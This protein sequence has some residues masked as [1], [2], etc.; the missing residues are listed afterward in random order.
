MIENSALLRNPS[1]WRDTL[2]DLIV[3]DERR[4]WILERY[5][6]EDV[7]RPGILHVESKRSRH[8]RKKRDVL[9][10]GDAIHSEQRDGEPDELLLQEAA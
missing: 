2:A 6:F 9:R 7:G 8:P 5:P 10:W 4:L 1:D 3:S